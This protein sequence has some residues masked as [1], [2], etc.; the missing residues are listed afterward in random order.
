MAKGPLGETV[1]L[2]SFSLFLLRLEIQSPF[3]R[4]SPVS[5]LPDPSVKFPEMMGRVQEG[6]LL[7]CR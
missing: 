5:Y 2:R 4:E 1:L 7:L 3:R 6:H